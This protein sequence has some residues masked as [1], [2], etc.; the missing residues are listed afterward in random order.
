MLRELE[1]ARETISQ[2]TINQAKSTGWEARLSA[3]TQDNEDL[4]QELDVERQR[5]KGAETHVQALKER[6]GW[7]YFCFNFGD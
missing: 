1:E 7:S 3:T 6:C 5:A 4:R 2:L